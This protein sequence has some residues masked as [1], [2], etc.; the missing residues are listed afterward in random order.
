M[1]GPPRN[2]PPGIAPGTAPDPAA[3]AYASRLEAALADVL[4]PARGAIHQREWARAQAAGAFPDHL[5][6]AGQDRFVETRLAPEDGPGFFL[7][8]G[9][10][11]G[12]RHSN[13]VLFETRYGWSGLLVE[14]TEP[15]ARSAG[16]NRLA[17]CVCAVLGGRRREADFL[18]VTDGYWAMSGIVDAYPD[19]LLEALRKHPAHRET[20]TRRQVTPI[21]DLLADAGITVID[22]LSIDIEGAE[23]DLLLG[24]PFDRVPVRAWS[25]EN[26][27]RTNDISLLMAS[28]GYEMVEFIGFDEIYLAA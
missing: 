16:A 14:A 8:I 5:S 1:S 17:P 20:V 2:H 19:D 11:D 24:F 12:L 23:P 6:Q 7:D 27:A 9:A 10:G 18:E 4:G 13:T 28:H 3:A 22:Y 26:S 25:I 15:L 21:S